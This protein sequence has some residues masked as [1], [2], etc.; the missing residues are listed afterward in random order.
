MNSRVSN[1]ARKLLSINKPMETFSSNLISLYT[2]R[3]NP[4]DVDSLVQKRYSL[5]SDYLD[6][7]FYLIRRPNHWGIMSMIIVF[8]NHIDYAINRGWIPVIDLKT[9]KNLY[10]GFNIQSNINGWEL[11]FRQPT[12]FG[13]ED[14]KNA[15]NIVSN[16]FKLVNKNAL[17][18]DSGL[19]LNRNKLNH[20]QMLVKQHIR[21]SDELNEYIEKSKKMIF[22]NIDPEEVLGIYSRGTDYITLRPKN[23]PIQPSPELIIEHIEP[24]LEEGLFKRIYLVTEDQEI[25]NKFNNVYGDILITMDAKRYSRSDQLIAMDSEMNERDPKINGFEYLTS[26]LLLNECGGFVGGITGGTMG[27]MLFNNPDKK[28]EIE[29]FFDLGCY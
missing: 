12:E 19:L 23:H 18:I 2:E 24:Y 22:A 21:F 4:W 16:P 14:I 29:Y 5:G 11:F 17:T 28:R 15:S 27:M 13:L 25:F 3:K 20:W 26:M 6:K 8:L 10:N 1:I 9:V 7:T